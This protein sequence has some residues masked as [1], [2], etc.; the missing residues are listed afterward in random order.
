MKVLADR[1]EAGSLPG[2]RTDGYR[3]VPA[4]E[5]GGMRGT[6]RPVWRRPP[7]SWGC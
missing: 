6:V 7:T 4:I 2:A 1:T 5:G 3:V